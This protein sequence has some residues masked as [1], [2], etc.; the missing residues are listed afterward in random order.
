MKKKVFR[1]IGSISPGK[2]FQDYIA[3]YYGC[4]KYFYENFV[5]CDT[6]CSYVII[7]L[8]DMQTSNTSIWRY[9]YLGEVAFL[10]TWITLRY[11]TSQIFVHLPFPSSNLVYRSLVP[12]IDSTSKPA[13][14]EKNWLW[15]N[16]YH[17][18]MIMKFRLI[19]RF[20]AC[21]MAGNIC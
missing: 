4:I 13:S 12:W 3:T 10:K 20:W 6:R 1:I 14:I 15:F 16:K 7:C 11:S 17:D 21:Y 5:E 18:N 8:T 9:H 19:Q 2:S